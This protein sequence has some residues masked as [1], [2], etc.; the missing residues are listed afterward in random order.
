MITATVNLW[1]IFLG[2]CYT[3]VFYWCTLGRDF[4]ATQVVRKVFLSNTGFRN[5]Y[6]IL[7]RLQ[8]SLHDMFSIFYTAVESSVQH[9]I[10]H[11]TQTELLVQGLTL[12]AFN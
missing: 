4:V 11:H 1:E 5:L 8:F 12:V 6:L 2:G 7:L 9:S 10:I 3:L